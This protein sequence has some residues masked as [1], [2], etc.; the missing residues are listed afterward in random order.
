M[1]SLYTRLEHLI[2][3]LYLNRSKNIYVAAL[4]FAMYMDDSGTSPDQNVA[5]AAGWIAKTPSWIYFQRDWDKVKSIQSDKFKCMHMA[6][7][8]G[9]HEEFTRWGQGFTEQKSR[10]VKKITKILHK[11]VFNG[12]GIGVVQKDFNSLVPVALRTQGYENHYTYA[13]R[14]VLGMISDWRKTQ[15]LESVPV[16]YIF[17]YM[18]PN[19]PCRLEIERVFN[20]LGTPEENFRLYGLEPGGYSFKSKTGLPP[21]QMADMFA[22]TMYRAVLHELGIIKLCKLGTEAFRGFYKHPRKLNFLVGGYH[23]PEHIAEWVKKKG[24]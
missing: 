11:R 8:V 14:R 19:N 22:W 16:H 20:T 13:I 2:D 1:T 18:D 23:K 21:L 4:T 24:F 6:D 17:D 3:S 7:F 15:R 12:F 10:V 5:V 9:G